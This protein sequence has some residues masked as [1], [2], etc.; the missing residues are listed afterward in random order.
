MESNSSTLDIAGAIYFRPTNQGDH[1]SMRLQSR[2]GSIVLGV[3]GVVYA[4]AALAILVWAVTTT[5]S[6]AGLLDYAFY[7][8]LVAAAA[9]GLWFVALAASSLGIDIHAPRRRQ[10]TSLSSR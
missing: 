6:F 4:V 9:M 1:M 8:A 2:W 5:G 10:R 7:L 3:V